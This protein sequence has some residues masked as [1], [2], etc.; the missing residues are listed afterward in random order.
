MIQEPKETG[1][2]SQAVEAVANSHRLGRETL[3]VRIGGGLRH[4]LGPQGSPPPN[5]SRLVHRHHGALVAEHV[6]FWRLGRPQVQEAV[7]H[8]P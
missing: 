5:D 8:P 3:F 7:A 2:S 4:P 6:L 1:S